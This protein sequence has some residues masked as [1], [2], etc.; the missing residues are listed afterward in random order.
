MLEHPSFT[1]YNIIKQKAPEVAACE[2]QALPTRHPSNE[3]LMQ[4]FEQDKKQ[5]SQLYFLCHWLP[6]IDWHVKTSS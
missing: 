3:L 1:Y 6:V 4:E 5:A 2:L